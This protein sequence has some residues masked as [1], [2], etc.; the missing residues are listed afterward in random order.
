MKQDYP[1]GVTEEWIFHLHKADGEFVTCRLGSSPEGGASGLPTGVLVRG[2]CAV[3]IS[4]LISIMMFV[5]QLLS[6]TCKLGSSLAGGARGLPT[7]GPEG[8]YC[9]GWL[10]Q[11]P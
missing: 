11:L 9:A 7:G 6:N 1:L 8:D 4:I 5:T 3:L 10:L 2:C